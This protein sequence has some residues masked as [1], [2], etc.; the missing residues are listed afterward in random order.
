MLAARLW[1]NQLKP[2]KRYSANDCAGRA[3]ETAAKGLR[4][5]LK[6]R[7]FCWAI[8]LALT[9]AHPTISAAAESPI[10]Y[11]TQKWIES[12]DCARSTG[13]LLVLC[14][15]GKLV[16]I[17][18]ENPADDPGHALSLDVYAAITGNPVTPDTV[19]T[20]NKIINRTG[21]AILALLL[22]SL[23]LR[24]SALAVFIAG[25]IIGTPTDNYLELTGPHTAQFGG[26]CLS[27]ILPL[28]LL[29]LPR[30][31]AAPATLILWL[32]VGVLGLAASAI[33]R[34]SIGLIGL[35]ASILAILVS[36]ASTRRAPIAHA[37]LLLL[38]ILGYESSTLVLKAR[39]AAYGIAATQ[40]MERHGVWHN[41][42]LGL[43]V[44]E[45]PFG[46]RWDD[47]YGR[48]VAEKANPGVV[49]LSP[50][51]YDTL[52]Q[53]YL[54]LLFAHPLEIGAVYIDKFHESIQLDLPALRD[55]VT[56]K[57][58][59][60]I[61]LC[62]VALAK[63]VTRT[64]PFDPADVAL[65]LS[66][67]YIAAFLAQGTLFHYR[68]LYAHPIQIFLLLALCAAIEPLFKVRKLK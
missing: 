62:V 12:A 20:L 65:L 33:L 50:A 34:Q 60:L 56:L 35:A 27:A 54:N 63:L 43:G 44:N 61:V 5:I 24:V 52:K 68:M 39:D 49:Y 46:I 64:A 2:N 28:A 1:C 51:Y 55:H 38:A 41:L 45:N 13:A 19:I 53:E 9:L 7:G 15:N 36:Y 32:G 42:Y 66:A 18:T 47:L 26:V 57:N 37:A 4:G 59:L 22:F 16:P 23:R 10:Q 14:R 6:L 30:V 58:A 11:I 48:Q 31:K 3:V 17:A 67:L 29:G 8:L 21:A 25:P 40:R